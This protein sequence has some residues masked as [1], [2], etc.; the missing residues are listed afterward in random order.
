MV[1]FFSEIAV[2]VSLIDRFKDTLRTSNTER[3]QGQ[4]LSEDNS[5]AYYMK[6]KTCSEVTFLALRLLQQKQERKHKVR[7]LMK[8]RLGNLKRLDL[9][10]IRITSCL[11]QIILCPNIIGNWY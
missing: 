8:N 5:A 7:A 2:F 11:S 10:E 9:K 3:K 4:K 1:L 6:N